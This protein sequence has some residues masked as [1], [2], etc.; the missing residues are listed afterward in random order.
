MG[1][2]KQVAA[3]LGLTCASAAYAGP[4]EMRFQFDQNGTPSIH[5]FVLKWGAET[6]NLQSIDVV[7][8]DTKEVIQT[9]PVPQDTVKLI[10]SDL[11]NASPNS[12]KDQFVDN[13]DY[14]FD[15]Y[16]DLRITKE[17]PYKVG[18]KNYLVWL[19]NEEKNQYIFSESISALP[20]PIPNAK[21]QW[22]EAVTL[23]GYGGGEY[24]RR[25]YSI[26]PQGMLKVQATVTQKLEDGSQLKFIRDI[27]ERRNG[28]LQRV[29]KL[30]VPTEGVPKRIWGHKDSC[31][32]Y[33]VE[34]DET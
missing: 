20:A 28:E 21:T 26:N 10:Y 6:A 25:A 34:E 23:G 13:V 30:E 19:F 3:L 7:V 24:V 22:I 14:N 29:C 9:I 16:A 5:T 17:W 18:A 11:I 31:K 2:L 4:F 27:R 33:M 12:V 1:V 15:K 8:S 32:P